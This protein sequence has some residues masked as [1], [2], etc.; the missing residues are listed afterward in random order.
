MRAAVLVLFVLCG[1]VQAAELREVSMDKEDGVFRLRSV[2]WFDARQEPLYAVF[3]NYDLTEKFSSFVVESRNLGPDENG[4]RRFFIRNE[5]CVWFF[6]KSFE[7]TGVVRH[8]RHT[9]IRSTA[10]ADQ[11]DFETSVETWTF[12]AEGAGTRVVYTWQFRPTF[13]IPPLIGPYV[14]QHKLERDA[15]RALNRIEAIARGEF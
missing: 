6:C 4:Q 2:V 15:I 5:G 13:W 12:E 1:A 9:Y 7:R 10:Y 11:S 3:L 14:L 8:E